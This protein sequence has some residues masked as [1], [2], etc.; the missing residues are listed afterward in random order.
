MVNGDGHVGTGIQTGSRLGHHEIAVGAGERRQQRGRAEQRRGLAGFESH[1]HDV[2]TTASEGTSRVRV[3]VTD[4]SGVRSTTRRR[5]ALRPDGVGCAA[6]SVPLRA[7]WR[8]P[9]RVVVHRDGGR[10]APAGQ[11]TPSG[12]DRGEFGDQ[13]GPRELPRPRLHPPR[14]TTRTMGQPSHR[15]LHRCRRPQ[16]RG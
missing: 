2:A 7:T 16:S 5:A 13:A 9:S 8:P 12:L 10:P 4:G 15:D 6:G 1:L 3:A 11:S 14:V